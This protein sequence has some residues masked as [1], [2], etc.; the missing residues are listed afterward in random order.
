MKSV[1]KG[2]LGGLAGMAVL[3]ALASVPVVQAQDQGDQPPVLKRAPGSGSP[4]QA[5]PAPAVES[6]TSQPA[7]AQAAPAAQPE[8][9]TTAKADTP[10]T[11]QQDTRGDR[12]PLLLRRDANTPATPGVYIPPPPGQ[13]QNILPAGSTLHVKLTTTL[14]SKTNK[15]GDPFTGTVAQAVNVNGTEL[16]PKGSSV[17]GHVAFVKSSG[18][19][20]GK[21]EMRVV[22][23]S[24]TT[25][26]DMKYDLNATLDDAAGGGACGQTPSGDEGTIKGCGK[27][28]KGALKDAAIAGGVGAGAGATVG[29]GKAIECEY[30]GMCNGP[31]FGTDVLAGAGIGVGTALIYNIFKHEKQIVLVNGTPLTFIV[32]RSARGLKVPDA[33]LVNPPG[34]SQ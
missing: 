28:K 6:K 21:A 7:P 8:P 13:A 14:T 23:D 22:L 12:P 3:C 26:D 31:G 5:Q 27:S 16:I 9:T 2:L 11:Q 20:A 34:T 10:S 32:A 29:M 1:L 30:Y 17:D 24:I 15:N 25:P 18:R 4:D 33:A 19:V